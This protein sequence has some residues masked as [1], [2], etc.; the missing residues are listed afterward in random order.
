M[1]S[2]ALI[3]VSDLFCFMIQNFTARSDTIFCGVFDGHGRH[4]HLVAK[5]V[6]DTLPLKLEN[7]QKTSLLR[8]NH[9]K[10]DV[11]V[12][13]SSVLLETPEL[14]DAWKESLLDAYKLMDRELL[15]NDH[16]DCVSSGTTA[17]TL[18]KQVYLIQIRILYVYIFMRFPYTFTYMQAS[19][20]HSVNDSLFCIMPSSKGLL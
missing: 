14:V 15:I 17:I 16:V 5:A 19:M 8:N 10:Q 7:C 9:C 4:G 20:I 18:V 1:I 13:V 11:T 12:D 2:Q 6:R 3:V